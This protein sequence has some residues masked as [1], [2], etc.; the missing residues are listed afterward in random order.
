MYRRTRRDTTIDQMK[1]I[2]RLGERRRK[3]LCTLVLLTSLGLVLLILAMK[4]HFFLPCIFHEVTGLYCPGC[5][6]SR[7]FVALARL[8]FSSA[9]GHNPMV[10]IAMPFLTY[11]ITHMIV[12]YVKGYGYAPKSW[13]NIVL[14]L[15]VG[16]FLL[17]GVLRNFSAFHWMAP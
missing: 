6:I 10:L 8:D 15:L 13:H 2:G 4:Y 7:M 16:Y 9:W 14:Y 3:V 17:F 12:G 5:G 11:F 1:V